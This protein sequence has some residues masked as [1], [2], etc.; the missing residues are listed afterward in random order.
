MFVIKLVTKTCTSCEKCTFTWRKKRLQRR[1]SCFFF[2]FSCHFEFLQTNFSFNLKY[3]VKV[4]FHQSD[5][6]WRW[7]SSPTGL[8]AHHFCWWVQTAELIQFISAVCFGGLFVSLNIPRII[9]SF[10]QGQSVSPDTN[11]H[12][13]YIEAF[14]QAAGHSLHLQ[15]EI[16]LEVQSS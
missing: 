1:E 4:Y 12:E 13:L 9:L 15:Q 8:T 5:G 2:P 3:E 14:L 16:Q 7:Y 6:L 11:V 10:S